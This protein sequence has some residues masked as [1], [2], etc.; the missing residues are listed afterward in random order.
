VGIIRLLEAFLQ[1]QSR[2]ALMQKAGPSV[3]AGPTTYAF[4]HSTNKAQPSKIEAA[5][6]QK[7]AS[8]MITAS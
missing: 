5:G 6:S 4:I 1:I 2:L 7:R 8:S 3:Y